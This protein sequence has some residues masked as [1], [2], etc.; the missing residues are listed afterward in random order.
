MADVGDAHHDDATRSEQ[1]H[2][3]AQH[4]LSVPLAGLVLA[5]APL[6]SMAPIDT[7]GV[8]IAALIASAVGFVAAFTTSF[9]LVTDPATRSSLNQAYSA[10]ASN[11]GWSTSIIVGAVGG[12][13]LISSIG[14]VASTV[15]VIGMTAF[16]GLYCL[17]ATFP[18]P[19][20]GAED[21][22]AT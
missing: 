2:T 11:V 10:A 3:G 6:L 17:R 8:V 22:L 1:P 15:T 14:S 4:R 20:A 18:E 9:T 19:V 7:P 21:P 5:S 12:G 16:I 13:I